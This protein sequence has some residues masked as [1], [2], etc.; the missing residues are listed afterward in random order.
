MDSERLPISDEGEQADEFTDADWPPKEL[1]LIE[2]SEA[3]N[4]SHLEY[5]KA[6]Q[7]DAKGP[8]LWTQ[9]TLPPAP[10]PEA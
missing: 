5:L 8:A 4:T 3:L 2:I 7:K 10:P 9:L 6:M 1:A